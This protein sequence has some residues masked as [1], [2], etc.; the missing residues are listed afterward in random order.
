M[1][2]FY[3]IIFCAIGL[4]LAIRAF[5]FPAPRT[6]VISYILIIDHSTH[7][8]KTCEEIRWVR[9]G[10]PLLR[11]SIAEFGEPCVQDT[12]FYDGFD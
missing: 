12:I 7:N 5:P 1:K 9:T 11:P 4:I 2:F 8:V 3:G 6:P 10:D